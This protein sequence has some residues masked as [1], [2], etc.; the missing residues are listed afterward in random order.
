MKEYVTVDRSRGGWFCGVGCSLANYVWLGRWEREIFRAMTQRLM[1]GMI[2][3]HRRQREGG[4]KPLLKYEIQLVEGRSSLLPPTIL[5]TNTK[6]SLHPIIFLT[7]L[8]WS[9]GGMVEGVYVIRYTPKIP[10]TCM[11]NGYFSNLNLQERRNQFWYIRF[12]GN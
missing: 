1:L 7:Q 3:R 12:V 2:L 6:S 5:R 8:H 10:H 11:T 4:K 9:V